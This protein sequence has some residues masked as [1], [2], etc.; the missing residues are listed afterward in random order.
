MII[1]CFNF[2]LDKIKREFSA[3]G[4]HFDDALFRL[5]KKTTMWTPFK[6]APFFHW[7]KQPD[8]RIILSENEIYVC[9]NN[10]WV[11]STVVTS[12]KGKQFMGYVMKKIES[13]LRQATQY[14]HK[15]TANITMVNG[16]TLRVLAKS[17]LS[18]ERIIPAAVYEFYREASKTIVTVDQASLARIRQET[19]ITQE[20]LIVD[21]AIESRVTVPEQQ[22][23]MVKEQNIFADPPEWETHAIENTWDDLKSALYEYEIK[24]LAVIRRGDDVK[25]FADE[26]G[27]MIEVLI[28]GINEKAMDLMG[29]NLIDESFAIYGDYNDMVGELIE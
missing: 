23:P 4:I 14:K 27:I 18:I 26:C 17:G 3:A 19:L 15:L 20:A 9:K 10:E 6:D 28:D 25:S 7:Q 1:D 11:F 8:K 21:D 29:D 24:A 2:T 16:D 22:P 12:E 13:V 5:T